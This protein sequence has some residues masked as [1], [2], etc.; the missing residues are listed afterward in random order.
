MTDAGP[1]RCPA[2][3]T[4][5]PSRDRLQAASGPKTP[6]CWQGQG[7]GPKACLAPDSVEMQPPLAAESNGLGE[8][9]PGQGSGPETLAARH[10]PGVKSASKRQGCARSPAASSACK[11]GLGDKVPAWR[12]EGPPA[13]AGGGAGARRGRHCWQQDCSQGLAGKAGREGAWRCVPGRQAADCG[14]G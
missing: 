2:P 7:F 1:A 9:R 6:D 3:A 10:G 13:G 12:Q 11:Q 8:I 5:V 4:A 14:Q